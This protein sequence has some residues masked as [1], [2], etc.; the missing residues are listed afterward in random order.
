MKKKCDV[1]PARHS[2]RPRTLYADNQRSPPNR[3]TDF[4]TP[5]PERYPV[6]T[7]P[8]ELTAAMASADPE[9]RGG[10][11]KARA[12]APYYYEPERE[13]RWRP[14][15]VP[16]VVVANVAVFVIVMAVNDCPRKHN[17]LLGRCVGRF[18][19]RLSFQPLKENPL[20]G[21]SSETC[22]FS[23]SCSSDEELF[24]V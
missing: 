13:K 18:L 17:A 3:A 22:V 7:I 1:E 19:G 12:A 16:L 2:N 4:P 23:V 24:L 20:L 11:G 9:A 21:P 15:L 6:S 10:G 5:S 14:W 8:S